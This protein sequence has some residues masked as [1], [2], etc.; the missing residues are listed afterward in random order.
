MILRNRARN[1]TRTSI[2]NL[3]DLSYASRERIL[4]S[5]STSVRTPRYMSIRRQVANILRPP[6]AVNLLRTCILTYPVPRVFILDPVACPSSTL[7]IAE[8]EKSRA[9]PAPRLTI[10]LNICAT[11][12]FDASPSLDTPAKWDLRAASQLGDVKRWTMV[13]ELRSRSAG[14]IVGSWV[15]MMTRVAR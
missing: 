10:C 15:A 1:P 14:E 3:G 4:V 2:V 6:S 8:G 12:R 13:M 5:A 11:S 9:C 7:S